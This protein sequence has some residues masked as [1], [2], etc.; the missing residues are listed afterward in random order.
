MLLTREQEIADWCPAV[1]Q[2]LDHCLSLVRRHYHILVALEEDHRALYG[3]F[4][5]RRQSASLHHLSSD[6]NAFITA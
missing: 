1:A 6:G 3:G 4:K 2:R 5:V